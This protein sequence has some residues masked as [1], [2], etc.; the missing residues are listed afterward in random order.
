M[1]ELVLSG[2][3]LIVRPH[4][5]MVGLLLDSVVVRLQVFRLFENVTGLVCSMLMIDC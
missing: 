2:H 3:R 5:V 4:I 1:T